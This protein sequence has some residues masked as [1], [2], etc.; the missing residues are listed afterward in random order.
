M[1]TLTQVSLA[2]VNA[3][4]AIPPTVG[5]VRTAE[6]LGPDYLI[7][8]EVE[9]VDGRLNGPDGNPLGT[10]E[11]IPQR[12]V[13]PEGDSTLLPALQRRT[14]HQMAPC[15]SEGS[16]R[17][18]STTAKRGAWWWRGPAVVTTRPMPERILPAGIL[19]AYHGTRT[20]PRPRAPK[21]RTERG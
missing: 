6:L 13:G 14:W 10:R 5:L 11:Q 18:R 1:S 17:L 9:M 21:T 2:A 8:D 16:G 15:G 20:V 12:W 4:P 7:D 3:P 19:P